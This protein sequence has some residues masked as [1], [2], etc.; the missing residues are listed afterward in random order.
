M[1][2][3]YPN[4]RQIKLTSKELDK[5]LNKKDKKILDDFLEFCGITANPNKVDDKKTLMLQIRYIIEKSFDKITKNDLIKFANLL[6]GSNRQEWTKNEIKITFKKFLRWMYPD[7]SVRFGELND[8]LKCKSIKVNS[9]RINSSTLLTEN[10]IELMLRNAEG[11]RDKAILILCIELGARPHELRLL[12]WSQV[13]LDREPA[14]ITL[15]TSKGN[16]EGSRTLPLQDSVLHLER[17]KQEFCYP[18]RKD[19]D[20]VF[21]HTKKRNEPMSEAMFCYVIKKIAKKAGIDRPIYGYLIRHTR[22]TEIRKKGLHG[23]YALLYGGHDDPRMEDVYVHLN[24]D[25]LRSEVLTKV[26]NVQEPSKEQKTKWEK[27]I[28]TLK[29]TIERMSVKVEDLE[30]FK[31]NTE[32]RIKRMKADPKKF[33]ISEDGELCEVASVNINGEWVNVLDPSINLTEMLK[34]SQKVS[35]V[36]S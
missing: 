15:L 36:A 19:S 26:Y 34:A 7:W 35:Q 11:L 17:W 3:E 6:N 28:K 24:G 30:K 31:N 10:E 2:K 23:K 12:K 5:K 16:H 14:E 22:L 21:P 27:E 29:E 33:F 32:I 18:D 4:F 13:H 20:Y 9:K 8:I 1:K 25:D